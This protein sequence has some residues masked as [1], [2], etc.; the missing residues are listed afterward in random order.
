MADAKVHLMKRNIEAYRFSVS[1]FSVSVGASTFLFFGS[2]RVAF[3]E[4]AAGCESVRHLS[5]TL[6]RFDDWALV[7]LLL[8]LGLASVVFFVRQHQKVFLFSFKGGQIVRR[9]AGPRTRAMPSCI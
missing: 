1:I 3:A 6:L 9:M 8:C 5:E 7:A 2:A 4:L